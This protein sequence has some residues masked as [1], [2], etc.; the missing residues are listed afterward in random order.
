LRLNIALQ[1]IE[2]VKLMLA[3]CD[4]DERLLLDTIEGETD[5]L[6]L[7]R[8]LLDDN[9][10][11]E[12]N[13]EALKAQIEARRVRRQKAEQRIERR[14]EAIAKLI[15]AAGVKKVPLPEATLSARMGSA[16]LEVLTE[17]AVPDEYRKPKLL[18]SKTLINEAFADAG[19][20]PNWLTR[21]PPRPT[22]TVRRT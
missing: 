14:R 17:A 8:R 16:S 3:G 7:I 15:M 22:L 19:T 13:I 12:G 5:A 9:E 18:P 11:D 6:S 1:Q 4:D 20:L 10:A 2:D 21:N